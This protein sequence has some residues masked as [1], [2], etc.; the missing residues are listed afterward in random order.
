VRLA[1]SFGERVRTPR[2]CHV[3][4]TPTGAEAR[5]RSCRSASALKPCSHQ[6]KGALGGN[7]VS[8]ERGQWNQRFPGRYALERT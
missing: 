8:P 4:E 3:T 1:L 5:P 2:H 6:K 7:M